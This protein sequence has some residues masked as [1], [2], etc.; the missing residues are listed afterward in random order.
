M[1]DMKYHKLQNCP[2]FK[3][4]SVP[5]RLERV[6]EHGLCPVGVLASRYPVEN[7]SVA[8]RLNLPAVTVD[9]GKAKSQWRHLADL[10]LKDMHAV[11][12]KVVLGSDVTEIIIPQEVREGPRGSPFGVRTKLGW[13]VTG[14]LPG[15]VRN[16]ESV[17]FVRVAS[18][19]EELNELVKTWWKT[20]SFGCKYDSQ[21]QRSREDEIDLK[22]LSKTTRKVNGRY[23][24]GLIWKDLIRA[25]PNNRVI[26][27]KRLELLERRLERDSQ[28]KVKYTE[29]IENDLQKGYIKKLEDQELVETD[30]RE[31][32]LPHH[33]V[34]HPHK[35]GKVRRVSDAAARCQGISL[36]DCLSSGPDLL[37]SLVGILMRFRQ[38]LV[39]VSADIEAM[40]NQVAV[41]KEDQLV[42][43]FL[44]RKKPS[45]KVDVYQ[46]VRHIFGA[47]CSP[48][49]ANYALQRTAQD[50]IAAFP[51]EAEAVRR[52][53][54][55]DDL[56]KSVSSLLEACNLQ[57]GLV[58]L[59]SLGGFNLTK[60]ILNNKDFISLVPE[61]D[62][63]QSVRSIGVGD[64]LPT[65]RALGVFWD[66]QNDTFI[67]KF[68]PKEL[69]NT[70]RKVVSVTASIF[71]PIGFIAPYVI[72][73]K[74]FLQSLW[75]LRQ[76][77]D[78]RMPEELLLEWCGWQKELEKLAAFSVPRFYRRVALFPVSIQLHVF[79]DASEAAFCAVAYFRFEYHDGQR[80]CAFVAAKTHVAPVKPLSTPKLELQA[81]VLNVRL[82]SMIQKEH[83][84]EI[85][86]IYFWSDSSAVLGQIRGP[87][88][89]FLC[90]QTF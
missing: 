25:L 65:Q 22:S 77:W 44:W 56:F 51:L 79:G 38:E 23:E 64:M 16:S 81:A 63:A 76:G 83:D 58:K 80:Q 4:L 48:A 21:E 62:R 33:A 41:P 11:E 42:L 8:K 18:P 54:Y 60:W 61:K 71:D 17:Y 49:C 43:R 52:N 46:Y 35:P 74:I 82:A 47:K 29:T 37:N 68:K 85:P 39:A 15:Y 87:S 32:Y 19:E 13:V 90:K 10:K 34:V 86:I 84:Y 55:M 66:V 57:A 88:S 24:V 2:T 72:R 27:E 1:G 12:V 53:F 30:A 59:L 9:M 40:F 28:L 70:R 45:D 89:C 7:A 3:G 5:E 26:A 36:N 20:E 69:A 31:W 14:N 78:D 6:K 67:F 50:N 73:A 75:K